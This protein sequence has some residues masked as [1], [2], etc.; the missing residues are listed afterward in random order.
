MHRDMSLSVK[1]FVKKSGS[2]DQVDVRRFSVD[3]DVC[4]SYE[5][6]TAKIRATLSAANDT[7]IRLFWKDDEGE[8]ISF[9]SDDA[10]VEALGH[11]V[12]G[13][14]RVYVELVDSRRTGS[15]HRFHPQQFIGAMSHLLAGFTNAGGL[16]QCRT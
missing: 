5:Y 2:E 12:D 6:L 3:E 10:L 11:V 4:S 8:M 16:W 15:L 9:S 13:V 7:V 1:V 14:L